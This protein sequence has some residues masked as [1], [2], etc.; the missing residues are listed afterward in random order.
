MSDFK[1]VGWLLSVSPPIS[2]IPGRRGIVFFTVENKDMDSI[3]N[4]S[5]CKQEVTGVCCRGSSH[6]TEREC[7]NLCHERK[8]K[9]FFATMSGMWNFPSLCV[10]TVSCVWLFVTLWIG[11]TGLLC[12]WD[13]P[14]KN[15]GVGCHFLLQGIFPT[16]GLNLC[17]CMPYVGRH[18]FP[19]PHL[20]R[21]WNFLDQGSNLPPQIV[22]VQSLNHWT[23][24]EV[25]KEVTL[26]VKTC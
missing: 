16:Q 13:F 6:H 20:G 19:L 14:S 26:N 24:R 25:L 18:S 5:I 8:R 12:P 21:P 23:S 1:P 17:F 7:R 22:E 11:P 10:W 3:Q 15:T 2:K 9:F 4:K